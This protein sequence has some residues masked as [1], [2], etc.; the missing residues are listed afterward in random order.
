MLVP[1]FLN[2]NTL[3]CQNQR[4]SIDKAGF[5]VTGGAKGFKA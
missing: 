3:I 5:V 4:V 2:R 1:W